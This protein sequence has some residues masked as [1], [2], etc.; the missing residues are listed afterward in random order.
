M[1]F[2][3]QPIN[4]FAVSGLLGHPHAAV[5]AEKHLAVII[6]EHGCLFQLANLMTMSNLKKLLFRTHC[7]PSLGIFFLLI[8]ILTSHRAT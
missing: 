5:G 1:S 3:N 2:I 7:L 6:G 4:Y 8:P